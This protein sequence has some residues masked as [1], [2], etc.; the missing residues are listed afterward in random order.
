M[1]ALEAWAQ[2]V[3]LTLLFAISALSVGAGD[4]L[5][6]RWSLE[7][8]WGTFA[9][10]L[11]CY[12]TSSFF[13]LQTLTRKGLVVS[14]IIWSITSIIAFLFV[15]LVVFNETLSGIQLIGV[16]LGTI[17]LLLLSM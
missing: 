13:Y 7:P 1:D 5:A 6:K 4:Y 17:S 3:P 2:K 10:A 16:I 11:A 14:C 12:L 15:G 8:E 9:G